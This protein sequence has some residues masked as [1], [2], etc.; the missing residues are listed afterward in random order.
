[1]SLREQEAEAAE[2]ELQLALHLSREEAGGKSGG[3]KGSRTCW[4]REAAG[5]P[6]SSTS[7]PTTRNGRGS[8]TQISPPPP[9]NPPFPALLTSFRTRNPI[10]MPPHL[11]G[12]LEAA[13][14][15]LPRSLV[16]CR[17]VPRG[18]PT[19]RLTHHK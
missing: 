16:P 17:L 12:R 1:M 5:R 15:T 7:G 2:K 4:E 9:Q 8:T 11:T 6:W 10:V 13:K 18:A 3:E 14:M 19:K